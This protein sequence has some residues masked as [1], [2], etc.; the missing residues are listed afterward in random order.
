MIEDELLSVLGFGSDLSMNVVVSI[1][2]KAHR[3]TTRNRRDVYDLRDVTGIRA[4]AQDDN[5]MK[6][7]RIVF[8]F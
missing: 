7:T 8:F 5:H 4:S 6:L 2:Q 3:S 1:N